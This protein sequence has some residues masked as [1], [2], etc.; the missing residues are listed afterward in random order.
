MVRSILIAAGL[1]A[2]SSAALAGVTPYSF[3]SGSGGYSPRATIGAVWAS[4]SASM[5]L[6]MVDGMDQSTSVNVGGHVSVTR[7]STF[8]NLGA[9]RNGG[10]AI[11]GSWD[12]VVSGS[13]NFIN[14]IY[15]TSDGSQ[16]MPVTAN[17]NGNSA[18][19]WK[20]QFGVTDQVTYQ[21]W[22]QSVGLVTA[23]IYFSDNGGQSFSSF[24][25]ISGLNGNFNS[26]RDNGN[27]LATI[28]DGTNYILVQYHITPVPAP[29]GV[30]ALAGAGLLLARRRR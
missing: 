1:T 9:N 3:E 18:F 30:A 26:G 29:A 17:V 13:N 25:N 21:P 22:V 23:R 28:G 7:G 2:M 10:G 6:L 15:K 8:T 20:W 24:S 19:F 4:E 27:Y 5:S 14:V 16:F 11:L 12:E